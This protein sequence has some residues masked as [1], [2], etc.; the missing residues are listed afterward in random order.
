MHRLLL[1]NPQTGLLSF[2]MQQRS[3]VVHRVSELAPVKQDW[4]LRRVPILRTCHKCLQDNSFCTFHQKHPKLA[5]AHDKSPQ[6]KKQTDSELKLAQP[7]FSNL[8]S[9]AYVHWI[10]QANSVLPVTSNQH[11]PMVPSTLK[12]TAGAT[13]Y[14]GLIVTR[15]PPLAA[16]H[17]TFKISQQSSRKQV[18]SAVHRPFWFLTYCVPSSSIRKRQNLL[19][20]SMSQP[21]L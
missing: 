4:W 15:M 5:S 3:M 13:L 9:L 16:A 21:N 17:H 10:P 8:L 14:S 2:P 6:P 11:G 19:E 1:F 18:S 12:L 20:R 7:Y